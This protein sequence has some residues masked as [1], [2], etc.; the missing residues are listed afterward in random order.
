MKELEYLNIINKT[1][2]D[3]SLLGDD[4]AYLKEFDL[5]ITQDT[6][7]EGVHFLLNTTD[8]FTLAQKSVNVNLSDLAAAGAKPLYIT[9]S[10][11]LPKNIDQNFVEN[12]YKGV[13][14]AVSKYGIKVAGGDL[15]GADRVYISICAIGKKYNSVQVSRTNAKAGDII[16]L[17][18]THGSS[19]G[20]L[21]LL[22]QGKKE[23]E[24]L[25]K[26]HLLPSAQVEKSQIILQTAF[27]CNVK[28]IAMM[29]SS[30]GL[31]DALYKLSTGC[32]YL[33]DIDFDSIPVDEELKTAFSEEWKDLLM[34]GGEDF[35]LVFC[36]DK[37][38]FEK[39]DKTKFYKIGTVSDKPITKD[40]ANVLNQEFENKIFKHF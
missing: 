27:D 19:A 31:G 13:E 36:I 9:L 14:S 34:W 28:N 18:G 17:T 10:L 20:G 39:L 40:I 5:C 22:L 1:L 12:F 2:T 23:P 7:V 32:G 29:D 25:I 16:A 35:E 38:A 30:D 37:S 21:K 4:C 15:T 6:L 33:F 24:I 8:A 3:S 11:S 26:K